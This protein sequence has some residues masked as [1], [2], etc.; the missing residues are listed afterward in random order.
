MME[1]STSWQNNLIDRFEEVT[2]WTDSEC[3]KWVFCEIMSL[4]PED[5]YSYPYEK[6]VI[7]FVDS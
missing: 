1:D 6:S 5:H 2:S 4:L 3:A 7:D